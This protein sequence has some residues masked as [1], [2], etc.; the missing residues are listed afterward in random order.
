MKISL[1]ICMVLALSLI[2]FSTTGLAEQI[3]FGDWTGVEAP[4]PATNTDSKKIRTIAKDGISTLWLAASASGEDHLQLTLESKKTIVS[5]YFSY[6][7]DRIDTLT[8]HSGR[9]GCN[10][11]CLTDD[12]LKNGDFIN[13]LRQGLSVRVE[14]DSSPDDVQKSTFSLK[15]FTRAYNWL[16]SD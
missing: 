16:L 4:D 13:T 14:Y 15:G 10:G 6:R 12:V 8:L 2:I 7:V 3:K 11:N 5:D 9:K 1:L